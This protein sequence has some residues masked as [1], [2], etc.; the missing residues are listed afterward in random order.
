MTTGSRSRMASGSSSATLRAFLG[1]SV[2]C[3]DDDPNALEGISA[4]LRRHFDVT[5]A[6]GAAAGLEAL[7]AK[8]TFAVVLSDMQMPGM[9]GVEFLGRVRQIAPDAVR[10][11]LTGQGDLEVAT[12]AINEGQVFR[13]LTKPCAAA[14]LIEAFNAAVEQHR[15]I[16]AEK[17]LLEQTLRGSIKVLVDVLS[18]TNPVAFGRA[19]RIRDRAIDLAKAVGAQSG[20]QIEVAALLSQIGYIALPQST[21][22]KLNLAQSLSAAEQA[23]VANLP[24]TADNLLA[25]IPRLEEVRFCLLYQAKH[26]DGTGQPADALRGDKIPLG[27][28]ILKVVLD[29]DVLEAQGH[30]SSVALGTMRAR[31]G[32]YD[33]ALLEA[34]TGLQ[35]DSAPPAEVREVPLRLVRVGMTF[36]DDVRTTSGAL[37]IPRGYEVTDGLI[38][39]IRNFSAAG[40]VRVILKGGNEGA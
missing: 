24:R 21:M 23:A 4:H 1:V 2:L 9:D 7:Q 19:T 17:V 32:V 20:W 34:F 40:N 6:V 25:N 15:L 3:V 30:R 11:L 26:F 22:D 10:M 38:D 13:F 35:G 5:T 14:R 27:A 12:A 16:T 36:A 31:S 37:L 33:P 28:R 8:H 29:F 18:L 39:R